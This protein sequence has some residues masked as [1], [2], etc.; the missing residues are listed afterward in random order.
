[1]T[2]GDHLGRTHILPSNPVCLCVPRFVSLRVVCNVA[3][4]AQNESAS[5]V[6]AT[7]AGRLIGLNL[8]PEP[9]KYL[10]K[11]LI[12]KTKAR[13]SI[14]I[15]TDRVVSLYSREGVRIIGRIESAKQVIATETPPEECCDE[16][17][18][19]CKSC[20]TD[21][22][23]IGDVV[24]YTIKYANKSCQPIHDVAIVDSLI[25]RLD[26]IPGSQKSS[27]EAIF[28]TQQNE[29]GTLILRWEIKDPIAAKQ[30]GE[31]SF[32]ARIK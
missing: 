10:D 2:Y 30:G 14:D 22:A 20:S 9:I 6:A 29:V 26:Y 21:K 17:L 12:N 5:R 15:G 31:V 27:R 4:V 28:V 25:E 23:Q 24:T 18:E 11:A 7:E 16:P 1:M 32:Q 19:L 8:K 3:G 13:V